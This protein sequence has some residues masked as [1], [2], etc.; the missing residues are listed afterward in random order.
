MIKHI[1]KQSASFPLFFD[2]AQYDLQQLVDIV[3]GAGISV[4]VSNIQYAGLYQ[5][6]VL[7]GIDVLGLA[8]NEFA[9]ARRLYV[10]PTVGATVSNIDIEFNGTSIIKD[11]YIDGGVDG[12]D[13]F[14]FDQITHG[15]G[16]FSYFL[17]Y[18]L[19]KIV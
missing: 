19:F 9:V 5:T 15:G 3:T 7:S 18:D 4:G 1:N 10:Y 17:Q 11:I 8:S 2:G 16:D 12:F 13:W 6:A 14:V